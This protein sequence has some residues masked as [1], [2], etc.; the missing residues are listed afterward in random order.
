MELLLSSFPSLSSSDEQWEL[1]SLITPCFKPS[2]ISTDRL[3]AGLPHLP[4]QQSPQG[5]SPFSSPPATV[6]SQV[7]QNPSTTTGTQPNAAPSVTGSHSEKRSQPECPRP[8][9][10]CNG[11]QQCW[12]PWDGG[13]HLRPAGPFPLQTGQGEKGKHFQEDHIGA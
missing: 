9:N 11:I 13:A 7:T 8:G 4:I 12:P 6:S 2:L 1:P 10:S 3:N 5:L